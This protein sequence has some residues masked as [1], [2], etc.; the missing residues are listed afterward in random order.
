MTEELDFYILLN[1]INLSLNG[2]IVIT[3]KLTGLQDAQTAGQAFLLGASG[4]LCERVS[5]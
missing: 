2:V 5:A 4:R 1:F 3:H